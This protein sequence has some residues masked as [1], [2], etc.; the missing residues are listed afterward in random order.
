MWNL[1]VL[2]ASSV[3]GVNVGGCDALVDNG[4]QTCE[5]SARVTWHAPKGVGGASEQGRGDGK[6][7]N[8]LHVEVV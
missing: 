2:T 3:D 4:I 5:G 7:G 1:F 6:G 8:G